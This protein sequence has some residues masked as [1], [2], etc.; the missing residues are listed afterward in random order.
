M[1]F[2]YELHLEDEDGNQKVWS[3]Q[4]LIRHL[5]ISDV[6]THGG[7]KMSEG[8]APQ[9]LTVKGLIE[10]AQPTITCTVVFNGS[11]IF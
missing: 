2:D 4:T 11:P 8:G 1:S 9:A 7:R 5:G 3:Y 6:E 10:K